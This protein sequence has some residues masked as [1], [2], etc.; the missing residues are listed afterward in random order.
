MGYF[1]D[2]MPSGAIKYNG[3]SEYY[4]IRYAFESLN[5]SEF[6][7]LT[8]D[9]CQYL[10]GAGVHTF[11]VGR[12][13]G[14]DSY[15]DGTAEN[16]PST[17]SPWKGRIIIQAKHTSDIGASCSDNNFSV[18]KTSVLKHEISR[19]KTIMQSEHLDGYLVV[20][21][22]KLTGGA[23]IKIKTLISAELNLSQV[24]IVG[25][26]DLSRYVDIIPGLIK[27]FR[28]TRFAVPDVFY[29]EDI[30]DV[31]VMFKSKT[32]WI[33]I[34]PIQEEENLDYTDKEKKNLLN[35]VDES[36]FDEIKEHSLKHFAGITK[37][38]Q[39]P[40]NS[41]YLENYLNT[42]ADLRSYVVANQG[43]C[44]FV[45]IL[46]TIIKNIMGESG[47]DIFRARAL[48]RVFVH[49]MYWNCDLG[50]KE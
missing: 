50:R 3:K 4:M 31:I 29:E 14:R 33:N 23:H 16:Y 38:L 21:N 15:F 32:D 39:D 7:A 2:G 11:A 43:T 12:D 35:N 18:N 37:F 49:Y 25:I 13:G 30:R 41:Q 17:A 8:V 24:D 48:V 34:P 5:E 47:T 22:R 26:E 6:E 45:D 40:I 36:Y 1:L 27:K 28:L 42:A 46:E 20:T 19:I 9:I 44:S 10:F